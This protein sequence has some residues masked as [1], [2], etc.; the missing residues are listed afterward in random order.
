MKRIPLTKGCVAIVDD[1]D[2]S[3]LSKFKWQA[4]IGRYTA[5][6]VRGSNVRMHRE[7]MQPP[8]DMQIDHRDSDGLNN[9]KSNL[10]ICTPEQNSQNK[11][12]CPGLLCKYKGV[13]MQFRN[14]FRPYI[15]QIRS[16]GVVRLL[17]C[18][19]APEQ[20]A[21]EY[22]TAAR[23]L[24]GEFAWL[25]Q[26]HFSELLGA[27][28]EEFRYDKPPQHR[29]IDVNKLVRWIRK[30][31]LKPR[32]KMILMGTVAGL[33]LE[34]MGTELGISRERVRQI[35]TKAIS[36]MK[37]FARIEEKEYDFFVA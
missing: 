5:Y 8:N 18:F 14:S 20:A 19:G 6:A 26:D 33:T 36:R 3:R 13:T 16:N 10:R 25:N 21:M 29:H 12:P 32:H 17:G 35:Q 11:W 30:S 2:Y 31:D 7:I 24:F 37:Y 27:R 1:D 9:Q 4:H 22:D 23:E 15:A 28:R 34:E